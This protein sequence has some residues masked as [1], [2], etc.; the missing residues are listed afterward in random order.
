MNLSDKIKYLLFDLDG[1]L[2]HF[3]LDEFVAGYLTMIRE[4][5]KS[6]PWHENVAEWILKGTDLMLNNNGSQKN[7]AVFLDYF[8]KKSGLSAEKVWAKFMSFYEQ[9]FDDL[10]TISQQDEGAIDTIEKARECG[11][12]LILATQPI[13]PEIAIKKRL[14]WAGLDHIPFLLITDIKK[15][16]AC[17]PAEL[18]FEELMTYI[19]A[20][21]SE[22]LMIGN[23]PVTDMAAVKKDILTFFITDQ[24]HLSAPPEADFSGKFSDLAGL[25]QLI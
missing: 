24:N 5:F 8:T 19:G 16:S 2:L 11:Y 12:Q 22:C 25:L 20:K 23:D 7:Q 4:E 21:S 9:K 10:Q 14:A 1:T 18:Y 13:F 15:M 3:D 6:Y 17:K